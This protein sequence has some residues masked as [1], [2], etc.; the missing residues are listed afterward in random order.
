MQNDGIIFGGIGVFQATL[1]DTAKDP[2]VA[3]A[4][5][6]GSTW[7]FSTDDPH[8]TLSPVQN[9]PGRVVVSVPVPSPAPQT[10]EAEPPPTEITVTAT[11]T[12]PSGAT[13]TGT[14]S[15]PLTEPVYAVTVEQV[16]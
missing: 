16:R 8:A 2:P 10:T 5:P 1:M 3:V 6:N 14:L 9:E 15:V 12:D 7:Q 11:V 13:Q 4:I